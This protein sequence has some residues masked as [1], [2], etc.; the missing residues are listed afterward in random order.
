MGNVPAMLA[1][2]RPRH[3]SAASSMPRDVLLE[4]LLRLPA[5]TLCRLR[6]VCRSWRALLSDPR[7]VAA[8]GAR[9][10]DPHIAVS[11]RGVFVEE[12][13]VVVLDASGSG[14]RVVERATRCAGPSFPRNPPMSA[15][16]GLVL[17]L[18]VGTDTR[19]RRRLR[20]LDPATGAVSLLPG[21]RPRNGLLQLLSP[22]VGIV[23]MAAGSA[24]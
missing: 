12:A 18:L 21:R 1:L 19:R 14:R 22:R 3:S 10:T 20:V 24:R 8:H 7:F 15:H 13:D 23:V 11:V 2:R 6:V 16:R 17:L 9:H 5:K 4:I